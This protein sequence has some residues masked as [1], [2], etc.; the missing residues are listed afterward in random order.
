MND[1][2]KAKLKTLPDDPGVYFHK[3]ATGEIIYIGKAAVLKNRV[4][5]YFQKSRTRDPKTE[6]LVAEI[7]D[8]EWI[9][10]ETEIDALFL[11]AEMVRRYLPRYNIMLRDDKSLLY[12]RIDIK[13]DSPTVT[14]TRRP[15]DDGAEYFGPYIQG[16]AVRKALRLLR[17]IFPYAT[18]KE[19]ATM[20]SKL[21]EQIGLDP[22][23]KTGKT[24]IEAYRKNLR[25]LMSYLRGNRTSMMKEIESEMKSAAANQ[26]FEQ[27]T[28]LRNKLFEM[29]S[30]KKQIVFS[31]REFMDI[32]KDKGL[33]GLSDLLGIA[34]PKRIEGYDISHMSGTDNV[35]S[36]VVFTNGIPDKTEYRKFKMRLKGNNDFAHMNEALSRRLR[37]SNVK[38]WQLPGLFLIDGG[39]GQLTSAI[40]AQADQHTVQERSLYSIPMIGLAKREEQLVIKIEGSSVSVVDI[41]KR[42]K[43]F[44]GYVTITEDFIL[45]NLPDTSDIVKLLQRI[46]DESH[47]FAVSYHS[48]L[49]SKRQT[50][51]WLDEVPGIGPA[52]KK[53]LIR[54][55]GSS[56]G[57]TLAR[58]G[59]L[60]KLLGESKSTILKQYIRA[61]K[62]SN[63]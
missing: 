16:Y 50:T 36:M 27:A 41:E 52:T 38:K 26:E 20:G 15:L 18:S 55:F 53:K 12:V 1:E 61:E 54:T 19:Q 63:S 44:G 39:K 48:T 59:E 35:A 34:L 17:R 32:S 14:F 30:L 62:K 13:S 43:K 60:E 9:E 11:E 40:K 2:L 4:R 33:N 58:K 29:K 22:G 10:V 6:A 46:R 57:V 56:K 7:V 31:D 51:S 47:R 49:K 5:Q 37:P 23:V 24:S 42:A 45:I 25:L 8:T 28:R 21:Y 3:D